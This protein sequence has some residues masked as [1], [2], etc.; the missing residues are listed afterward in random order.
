[1]NRWGI[2]AFALL[3]LSGCGHGDGYTQTVNPRAEPATPVYEPPSPP[4]VEN[5]SLRL[6]EYMSAAQ[7]LNVLKSPPTTQELL[8]CGTSTA[9]PWSCL[10]WTYD[11]GS[12]KL[13][14]V[15][16]NVSNTWLVQGWMV[17]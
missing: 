17:I 16:T 10:N 11:D 1:M 6:S 3:L 5:L 2:A 4:T 13:M 12:N 14:I 15:F 9:H 7:V 8:T